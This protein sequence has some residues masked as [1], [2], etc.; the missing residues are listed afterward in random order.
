MPSFTV[1]AEAYDPPAS[2][3]DD[4][5]AAIEGAGGSDF[6]AGKQAETSKGVV[7]PFMFSVD[8]D[9]ESDVEAKARAMV[10]PVLGRQAWNIA[11]D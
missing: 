7:A 2:W 4:L 1:K 8:A 5:R 11:R 6:V 9:D 3:E 10:D